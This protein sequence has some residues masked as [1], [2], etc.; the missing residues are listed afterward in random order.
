MAVYLMALCHAIKVDW[1]LM[2]GSLP[3]IKGKNTDR[4][5]VSQLSLHKHLRVSILYCNTGPVPTLI[6]LY[7]A[8]SKSNI[9]PCVVIK[10]CLLSLAQSVGRKV[11]ETGVVR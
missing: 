1:L 6:K 7:R 3:P 8:Q 10:L 11:E 5:S 2:R 4:L 9:T